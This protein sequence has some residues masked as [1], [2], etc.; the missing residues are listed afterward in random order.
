M[1]IFVSIFLALFLNQSHA[2]YF[3]TQCSNSSGTVYWETGHNSNSISLKYANFVDGTLTL[4]IDQVKI[5]FL[6]E[7]TISE[8]NFRGCGFSAE[9]KVYAGSVKITAGELNPDVL[10]GQFP[11]NKVETEVICT[12][13]LNYPTPC[14]EID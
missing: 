13:Q 10:R 9:T 1:K 6:K 4:F 7:I 2:S 11:D 5:D 14:P 8:K 3:A 12:Y